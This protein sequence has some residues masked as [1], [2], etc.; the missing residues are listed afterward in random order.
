MSYKTILVHVDH[1]RHAAQRI[2]VAARLAVAENAHLVGAAM[3]GIS[4]YVYTE[5]GIDL[6]ATLLAAQVDALTER[7][8]AALA[9][10]DD[11]AARAGVLSFERRLVNDDP[12]GGL[13]Q[14]GRYADL[15][16][17]SQTDHDDPAAQV[18]SDVPEYV[19]LNAG[20]PVLIVPYAGDFDEISGHALLAWDESIEA[21]HAVAN[22]LPMLKRMRKVTVAIFNPV[23]PEGRDPGADIALYLAR[24]GLACEVACQH[25]Q[26]GVGDSLLSMAADCGSELI[27][28]GGYGH[29]RFRELLLGGVTATVLKTMTV[30]VLMSH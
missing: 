15:V 13:A 18:I 17:L 30:P 8:E 3:I 2:E 6:A 23:E 25:S 24:H 26:I 16:V 10:F 7:A 9:V 20:R 5:S 1:S 4:R 14:Q 27:V 21:T 19:M 29:T 28:M 12:A 22:A 11:I